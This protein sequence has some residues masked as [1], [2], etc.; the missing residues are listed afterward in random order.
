VVRAVLFDFY[1]TLVLCPQWEDLEIR[2]IGGRAL[3]LLI[4]RGQFLAG[5]PLAASERAALLVDGDRLYHAIRAEGRDTHLEWSAEAAVQRI[6]A[7][8]GFPGDVPWR[9]VAQAVED[10]NR[11]CLKELTVIPG[12]RDVLA[13]LAAMGLKLAVVSN[14]ACGGFVRWALDKCELA[15]SFQVVASSGDL[16]WRK[17]GPEIFNWTLA[18]LGVTAAEAVHVG[19]SQRYD[20]V[21]GHAANLRVAWLECPEGRD[22]PP[23]QAGGVAGGATAGTEPGVGAGS[24]PA[25]C[26]PDATLAN[27]GDLPRLLRVV[28]G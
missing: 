1:R 20:V 27:I 2:S 26:Q 12:V 16:G 25:G 28:A 7:T 5:R 10:L 13:E 11:A 3:A 22:L 6:L 9:D 24:E 18:R 17:P 19:D 23:A 21:G 4:D 8:M 15:P 14:A